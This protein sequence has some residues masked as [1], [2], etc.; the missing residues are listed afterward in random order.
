MNS[1]KSQK[2]SSLPQQWTPR[3]WL[4]PTLSP[5][6]CWS[7]IGVT[8]N[9]NMSFAPHV[10]SLSKAANFQ[11]FWISRICKYLT[12]EA[13]STLVPMLIMSRLDYCNSVLYGLP[14]T[15]LNELQLFLNSAAHLTLCINKFEHITPALRKL[16]WLPIVQCIKFKVSCLT[17]K[18]LNGLTSGCI[19]HLITSY[20][21]QEH[22]ALLTNSCCVF[23]KSA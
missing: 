23:P 3:Y 8:F 15:L 22:S 2:I 17:F 5:L 9:N 12:P 19:A 14:T 18:A 11:L 10:H 13:P 1:L 6:V 7:R 20:I 21:S 4:V 16:H